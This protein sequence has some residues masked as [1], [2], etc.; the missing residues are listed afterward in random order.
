MMKEKRVALQYG[1]KRSTSLH[2]SIMIR[3]ELR[4]L[5]IV[6][7]FMRIYTEI[8]LLNVKLLNGKY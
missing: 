7:P 6:K 2:N 1:Y 4:S 5:F 3:E 8:I